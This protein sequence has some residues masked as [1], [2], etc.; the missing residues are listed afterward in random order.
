V[1]YSVSGLTLCCSVHLRCYRCR[2]FGFISLLP[3]G[4]IVMEVVGSSETMMNASNIIWRI[5]PEDQYVKLQ[6]QWK[7][8]ISALLYVVLTSVQYSQV[9]VRKRNAWKFM[10]YTTWLLQILYTFLLI[11]FLKINISL[12]M[13]FLLVN[14]RYIPSYFH[15]RNLRNRFQL[16]NAIVQIILIFKM[17]LLFLVLL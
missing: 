2:S 15:K 5:K 13:D 6:L 11:C 16:L 4:S 10:A 8:E 14:F 7:P 12:V 17:V 9:S 1:W 3:A